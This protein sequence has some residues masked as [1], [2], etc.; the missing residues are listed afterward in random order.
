MSALLML[1]WALLLL[2]TSRAIPVPACTPSQSQKIRDSIG[3]R[4]VGSNIFLKTHCPDASWKDRF[5]EGVHVRNATRR[6]IV[7]S[8]GCNKAW[9]ALSTL[10][11]I[12]RSQ[13]WAMAAIHKVPLRRMRPL[14]RV[15]RCPRVAGPGEARAAFLR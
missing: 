13:V 12:T 7:Y 11:S 1:L 3:A 2:C 8:I 5:F 10:Q 4:D 9:D 15:A 14:L 6:I